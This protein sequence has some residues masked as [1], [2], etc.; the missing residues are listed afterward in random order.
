MLET[1]VYC[2]EGS[3]LYHRKKALSGCIQHKRGRGRRM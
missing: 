3:V 1:F 2:G